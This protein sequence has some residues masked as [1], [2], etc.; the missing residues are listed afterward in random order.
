MQCGLAGHVQMSEGEQEPDAGKDDHRATVG[1]DADVDEKYLA[2]LGHFFLQTDIEHQS[3]SS[4]S[5]HPPLTPHQRLLR[6]FG[7]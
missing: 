6:R 1:R 5:K 4:T 2:W 7:T 3:N